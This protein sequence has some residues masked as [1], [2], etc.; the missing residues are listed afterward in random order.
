[1]GRK[2]G[3]AVDSWAGGVI[4]K[5]VGADASFVNSNKGVIEVAE[6]VDVAHHAR[7]SMHKC[8]VVAKQFLR[9]VTNLVNIT[10][11][12]KELLHGVTVTEP[13]EVGTP[14]V[15]T[16]LTYGPA[17]SNG[18]AHKRVKVMLAIGTFARAKT[19]RTQTGACHKGVEEIVTAIGK[20][21]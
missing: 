7:R 19:N 9:Q 2:S 14:E 11:V 15:A 5:V 20:K 13:V 16:V 1:V 18:F 12:F 4:V 21:S 3:G 6:G 10:R 17:A 8:K